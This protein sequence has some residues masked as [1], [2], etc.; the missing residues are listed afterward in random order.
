[1]AYDPNRCAVYNPPSGEL[2]EGHYSL[3]A[4]EFDSGTPGSEAAVEPD[5]GMVDPIQEPVREVWDGR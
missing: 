5:A 2:P 1:M 4:D 3:R